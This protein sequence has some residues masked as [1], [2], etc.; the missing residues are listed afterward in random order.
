MSTGTNERKKGERGEAGMGEMRFF[1]FFSLYSVA[2]RSFSL[3]LLNVFLK[4]FLRILQRVPDKSRMSEEH[5][6]ERPHLR[7]FQLGS[8]ESRT[9]KEN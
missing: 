2:K 6:S 9:E 1:S 3:A 8:F 5:F 4:F 7:I